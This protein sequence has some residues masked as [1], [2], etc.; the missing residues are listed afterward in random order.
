MFFGKTGF[1][2]P[3]FATSKMEII[4]VP[5]S[6]KICKAS[7][8]YLSMLCRVSIGQ[9]CMNNLWELFYQCVSAKYMKVPEVFFP[10]MI[11]LP[12][13]SK[14]YLSDCKTANDLPST[15]MP[16]CPPPK[17]VCFMAQDALIAWE[18]FSIGDGLIH[19]PRQMA[20]TSEQCISWHS[21]AYHWKIA[22]QQYICLDSG[23][24]WF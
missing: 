15:G 11:D 14:D 1:P 4:T 17:L 8:W 7:S 19:L 23:D 13:R 6:L 12:T 18:S 3:Q 21:K 5:T 2:E 9:R 10:V 20:L 22:S 24:S 16:L